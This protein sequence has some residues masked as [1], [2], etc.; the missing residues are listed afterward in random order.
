MNSCWLLQF[1]HLTSLANIRMIG[2][3]N[4]VP[5]NIS[6]SISLSV[7]FPLRRWLSAFKCFMAVGLEGLKGDLS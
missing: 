1:Y 4:M 3:M 7:A 2:I 6:V 5:S